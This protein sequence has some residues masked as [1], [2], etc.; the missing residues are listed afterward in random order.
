LGSLG[1]ND[2]DF[3]KIPFCASSGCKSPWNGQMRFSR[4]IDSA[5]FSATLF[6]DIAAETNR[7][8]SEK[9][10]DAMPLKNHLIWVGW[11]DIITEELIVFHGVIFNMARHVKRFMKDFFSEHSIDSSQF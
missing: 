10:N 1:Q 2:R 7:Y 3:Y 8:L 5:I 6:E 4:Q 9:I 11:E